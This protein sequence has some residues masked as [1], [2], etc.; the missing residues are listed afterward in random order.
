V[1]GGAFLDIGKDTQDGLRWRNSENMAEETSALSQPEFERDE[2]F[3]FLYANHVWYDVSAW[4]L[5]LIFGQLDQSKGPNVVRQHTAIAMS[6]LQAKLFS[7]FVDVNIALYE[8]RHGKIKIPPHLLPPPIPSLT[9]EEASDPV[10]KQIN[11]RMREVRE[12]FLK[13]LEESS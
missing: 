12:S 1:V 6:W 4:D 2:D 7:H 8:A 5:N 9:P 3:V 13:S 11:E 10:K